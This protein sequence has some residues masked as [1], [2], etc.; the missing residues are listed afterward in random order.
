MKMIFIILGSIAL[1]VASGFVMWA[2]ILPALFDEEVSEAPPAELSQ[3][4]SVSPTFEKAEEI[5]P[6]PT[7]SLDGVFAAVGDHE[8]TGSAIASGTTLRLEEEFSVTNCPDLSLYIGTE[9]EPLTE[10][11]P[12]KGNVGSQNYELPSSAENGAYVW[13]YCNSFEEGFAKARL[14]PSEPSF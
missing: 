5:E 4:N 10:I 2:L 11:A 8:V 1:A 12:L 14:A 3:T 7:L 13:I 9:N 6:S